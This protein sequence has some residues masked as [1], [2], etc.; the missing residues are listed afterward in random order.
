MYGETSA[1][2]AVNNNKI[3]DKIVQFSKCSPKNMYIVKTRPIN[4]VMS[5]YVSNIDYW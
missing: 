5:L 4:V 3:F 1:T 2:I